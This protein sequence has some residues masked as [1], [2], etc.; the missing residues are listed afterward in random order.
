MRK[1]KDFRS[2]SIIKTEIYNEFI[3]DKYFVDLVLDDRD[4]VVKTWRDLGLLCLQVYY[5]DF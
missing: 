1:T 3:K 5:G 4:S 2:D